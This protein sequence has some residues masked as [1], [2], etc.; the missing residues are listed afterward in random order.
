MSAWQSA[1][2]LEQLV[3]AFLA[4]LRG[5]QLQRNEQEV[6][7]RRCATIEREHRKG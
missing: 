2:I 7:T 5:M 6:L 3:L 1:W 4:Q